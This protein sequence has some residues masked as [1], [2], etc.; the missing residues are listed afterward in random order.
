MKNTTV[1]TL[2]DALSIRMVGTGEY[3]K[4]ECAKLVETFENA[5]A[6]AYELND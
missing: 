3:V 2:G 4:R 6:E 1:F 5:E